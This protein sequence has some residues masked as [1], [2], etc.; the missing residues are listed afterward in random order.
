MNQYAGSDAWLTF[1]A[2]LSTDIGKNGG[3]VCYGRTNTGATLCTGIEAGT[4]YGIY[5]YMADTTHIEIKARYNP[6]I[7]FTISGTFSVE[8]YLIP[9]PN[10]DY[11]FKS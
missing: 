6:D 10:N 11:P 5:P 4:P 7:T 8:A 3:Y 1:P 9:Y 2:I